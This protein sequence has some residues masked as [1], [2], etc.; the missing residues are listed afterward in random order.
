MTWRSSALSS[1][2]S[3]FRVSSRS[4]A[5]F[6]WSSA[7]LSAPWTAPPRSSRNFFCSSFIVLLEGGRT[8]YG[9]QQF[10]FGRLGGCPHHPGLAED[11][12]KRFILRVDFNQKWVFKKR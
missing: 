2:V 3:V 1:S 9:T 12:L 10:Q 4:A 11:W 8:S 5:F 6:S 7:N